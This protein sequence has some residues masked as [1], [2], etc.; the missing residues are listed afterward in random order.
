MPAEVAQGFERVGD[1]AVREV[2]ELLLKAQ[3]K[4]PEILKHYEIGAQGAQK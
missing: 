4:W 1:G 3:G 2:V